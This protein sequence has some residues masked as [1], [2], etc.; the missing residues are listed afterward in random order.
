MNSLK[1]K[2]KT[3]QMDLSISELVNMYLRGVLD[4][5]PE[6]QRL[7]RWSENQKSRFIESILL[8]IPIPPIFVAEDKKSA[9]DVIDGV[10]RLSTIFEFMGILKDEQNNKVPPSILTGT[11]KVPALEGKVWDHSVYKHK[12]AFTDDEAIENKFLYSSKFRIIR[13]ENDSDDD[14]KYDIFNRLNTGASRLSNQEI[15]NCLAIMLNRDFYK[16]MRMLSRKIDFITCI[17]LSERNISEQADLEYVLRFLVYRYINRNEYSYSDEMDQILTRKMKYFCKFDCINYKKE[18]EI[19]CKTFELLSIA[20]GGNSF[21]KYDVKSGIF[22]GQVLMSVFEI[23]AIG[24]ANNIDEI[25]KLKDPIEFI[26]VKTKS[27]YQDH[28][29]L[30]LQSKK[31][32]SQRAVTR[33]TVLTEFGTKYFKP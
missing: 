11:E 7:F 8:G 6:F 28:K 17:P 15:R 20:L 12:F 9:Y 18:E 16:W 3:D 5:H 24:I 23:V 29:Y 27:L 19:F 30:E 1:K 21:K 10:Q 26:K 13:I 22:K 25:T 31:I 32:N 14:V 4:I 33:F 2:V